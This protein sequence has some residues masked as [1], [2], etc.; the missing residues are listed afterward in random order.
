MT[1]HADY[2]IPPELEWDVS[3]CRECVYRRTFED[4]APYCHLYNLPPEYMPRD[5]CC[6]GTNKNKFR[7]E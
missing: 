4:G 7:V 2:N 5:G 3:D 6:L 1:A